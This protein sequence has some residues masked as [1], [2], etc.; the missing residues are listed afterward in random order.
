MASG[1]AP[2]QPVGLNKVANKTL[3]SKSGLEKN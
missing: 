2:F 1:H 3:N